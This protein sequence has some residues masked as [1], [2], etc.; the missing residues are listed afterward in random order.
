MV[1]YIFVLEVILTKNISNSNIDNLIK[2]SMNLFRLNLR[3]VIYVQ[4]LN[5]RSKN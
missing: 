4:K 3:G 5:S 2:L 1:S